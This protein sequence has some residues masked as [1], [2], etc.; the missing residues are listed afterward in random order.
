MNIENDIPDYAMVPAKQ[1]EEKTLEPITNNAI[2]TPV[3]LTNVLEGQSLTFT[4]EEDILVPDIKPDLKEILIMECECNLSTREINNHVKADEYINISGNLTVQTLY[5]P[6]KSEDLYP[7]I[8]VETKIPFKEQAKFGKA[9]TILLYGHVSKIDYSIINERKYRIKATI[10]ITTK[11]YSNITLSIFDGLKNDSLHTL[12]QQTEFSTLYLRKKDVL[13]VKEYISPIDDSMPEQI[14]FKDIHITE[15]YKQLTTDKLIINGFICTNI[16]YSDKSS[17]SDLASKKLHQLQQKLEFTQF[18]PLSHVSNISDCALDFDCSDLKLKITKHEDGQD[19]IQL[20]GDLITYVSLYKKHEKD[21][22]IDGYHNEKN[23]VYQKNVTDVNVVVGTYTSDSSVREI[24]VP[25][26]LPCDIEEI[27]FTSG[28]II[29]SKHHHEKDKIVTEGII[30]AKILCQL[31]DE[32]IKTVTITD[33]VPYRI[34]SPINNLSGSEICHQEVSLRDLWSEK[35]NGKQLEFNA[36]I[37]AKT[38]LIKSTA[39]N[40]LTNPAYEISNQ[41]E[42]YSPIIIYC[43]KQHDSLWHIAKAFKTS[44]ESLVEINNLNSEVL[45][46]GQKLLIMR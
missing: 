44:K 12:T 19:I 35:I 28:Q 7:V 34:V 46:E 37:I 5:Y 24:F 39:I 26:E 33:E 30:L 15:N 29:T 2:Y 32:N 27:I 45:M 6:E 8:S 13:S 40:H 9:D 1:L 43:C 22:I 18:V 21:I 42:V 25:K 17:I 41:N 38:E 16:L 14:L 11:E 20:S 4:I 23:F 36:S 31:E 10:T 3:E